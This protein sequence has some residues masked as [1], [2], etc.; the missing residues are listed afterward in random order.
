M[1]NKR[2]FAVLPEALLRILQL[3][4]DFCFR[5]MT[6]Q[7]LMLLLRVLRSIIPS[8]H[9]G[10]ERIVWL[11]WLASAVSTFTPDAL[12]LQCKHKTAFSME[13]LGQNTLY[14]HQNQ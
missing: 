1:H 11:Q 12:G 2:C 7:L 4:Y 8:Y 6:Q 14:S 10:Y 13:L 5:C 3:P 9:S